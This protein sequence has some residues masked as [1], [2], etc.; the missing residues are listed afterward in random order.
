MNLLDNARRF[1]PTDAPLR[2]EVVAAP[3]SGLLTRIVDRGR[4]I[5]LAN[6]PRVW[7]RF[8]TTARAEGGTS[9][10]LAIV[11]AVVE[12]QGGQIGVE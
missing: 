10:G 4:G 5:S 11:R 9:L 8:F 3:G 12:A 1:S 6:L 7:D 2:A